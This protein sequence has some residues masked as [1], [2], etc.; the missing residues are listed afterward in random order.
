MADKEDEV[1]VEQTETTDEVEQSAEVETTDEAAAGEEE[2]EPKKKHVRRGWIVAGVIVIVLVVAVAGFWVWHEQP[3]FCNSFCHS[4]MDYYVETYQS[5][6]VGMMAALHA[7]EGYACLDCHDAVLTDQITEAMAWVADDYPL[8]TTEDGEEMLATGEDFAT[9][10]FC[11][12]SGC[13]DMTEVVENTWGFA[14]NEAEY[15]PHS[16]HQDTALECG[17]CHKAHED[18]VLVCNECHELNLP[19]GWEDPNE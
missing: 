9:E 14:D 8:T 17:D 1:D 18:S 4:P 16:S 19:E 11:A 2:P 6:D 3:S 12:K 7:D 13:H 15:N 10:E 5:D